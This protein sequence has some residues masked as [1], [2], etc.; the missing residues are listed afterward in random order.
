MNTELIKSGWTRS[1]GVREQSS[2][3]DSGSMTWVGEQI[4]AAALHRHGLTG[5][6]VS[7]AVID[8]GISRR[9]ELAEALIASV[10]LSSDA[11]D[12]AL[13]GRDVVGHGTHLAGIIAGRACEA[14]SFVGVAPGASL[15][16]VKVGDQGGSVT[17]DQVVEGIAWVI[18]NSRLLGI[19]VLNLAFGVEGI[20]AKHLQPLARAVRQA[21]RAGIVVVVATGNEGSASRGLSY[22]AASSDVISVGNVEF[23][24][25]RWVA[26]DTT[27][28][29]DGRHDPDLA[30][31]GRSLVSTVSPDS[32]AVAENPDS[33]VAEGFIKGTG[34]SQAAAVV[35]GAVALLLQAR[36][37]LSPRQVRDFFTRT[38][39]FLPDAD[40][41]R[42]GAGLLDLGALIEMTTPDE[43]WLLADGDVSDLV[44]TDHGSVQNSWKGNS[45]KGN[46]WKGDSW[47]GNSWKGD[48]WT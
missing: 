7:V 10:D 39:E 40:G 29:G 16:A 5:A 21:R 13:A 23:V 11:A 37:E 47:K 14:A 17:L 33:V 27:S 38:A 34:S 18:G 4:G 15:V 48:S 43:E 32:V 42:V 12:P 36:P 30:A 44:L 41:R 26:H 24:D 22:P 2:A 25:G 35:S 28:C 20:P 3:T 6:G 8:T 1:Y 45:W 31:P 19:R 9:P 46:S